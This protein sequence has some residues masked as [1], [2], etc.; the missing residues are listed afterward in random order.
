M[1]PLGHAVRLVHTQ[2]RHRRQRFGCGRKS[3]EGGRTQ[4][5]RGQEEYLILCRYVTVDIKGY[6]NRIA[7]GNRAWEEEREGV[8]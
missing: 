2:Q 7:Q 4:L 8:G 3:A 6:E 1:G 5:L